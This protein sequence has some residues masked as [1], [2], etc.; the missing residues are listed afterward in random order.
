MADA[1]HVVDALAEFL[2]SQDPDRVF[3][4]DVEIE[5]GARVP[6]EVERSPRFMPAAGIRWPHSLLELLPASLAYLVS[7][8]A[9]PCFEA[10][11]VLVFSNAGTNSN[12]ELRVVLESAVQRSST[13]RGR[14]FLE[15]GKPASGLFDPVCLDA[16]QAKVG[17]EFPLVQIDHEGSRP[18]KWCTKVAA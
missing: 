5:C 14:G 6:V 15:L 10:G 13:L 11:G 3:D 1:K 7:H 9:F 8:Y 16:R 4:I 18:V 2:N 17:N 12:R